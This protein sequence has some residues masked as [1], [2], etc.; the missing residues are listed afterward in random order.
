MK[1]YHKIESL[2]FINGNLTITVDEIKYTIPIIKISKKL[3]NASPEE[4]NSYSI[5]PSG[6]GIHWQSLDEDISIDTL[7]GITHKPIKRK[8]AS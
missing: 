1:K 6:Y 7:I 3:L 2:N 8:V 5:S 4:L